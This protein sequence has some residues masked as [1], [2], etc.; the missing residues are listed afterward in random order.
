MPR[1]DDLLMPDMNRIIIDGQV[2]D[3][4]TINTL[5]AYAYCLDKSG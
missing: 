1:R 2:K 4:G 3:E 5:N